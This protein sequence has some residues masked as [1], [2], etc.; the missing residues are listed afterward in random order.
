M[1]KIPGSHIDGYMREDELEWLY[2]TAK[3]MSSIAEIGCWMGRT[4]F[5][6]CS[7]CVNGTVYSV[8]HFKGSEEHQAII[9]EKDLHLYDEFIKN[10]GHFPNLRIYKMTSKEASLL[11]DSVD[12]VFIDATH[13]Y[14]DYMEDINLWRPKCKKMVAG[15]DFGSY[16]T[17]E[18]VQKQFGGNYR[19]GPLAIWYVNVEL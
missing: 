7:G 12:M 3:R 17:A 13:E 4:T 19:N 1:I 2:N 15:H 5:A 14:D 10:V 6:L 9:K 8:D 16:R 18:V 11:I